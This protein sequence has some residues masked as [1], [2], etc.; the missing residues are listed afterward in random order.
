MATQPDYLASA[1]C[2]DGVKQYPIPNTSTVGSGRASLTAGFPDETSQPIDDGGIPPQRKDFNGI[3]YMLS[4]FAL[5][6]QSGGKFTWDSRV[7]Y[8]VPSIIYYNGELWWCVSASGPSVTGVGAKTPND[9]N[10]AY[11]KKVKDL[12]YTPL[13]AYPVGSY[14]ISS[15]ATNPANLAGFAGSTWV[16]VQNRMILAAG[17]S[18]TAGSTG[19]SATKTLTLANMPKHSHTC[20]TTGNHSH[21]INKAGKHYHGAMGENSGFGSLYG[22][23]DSGNTHVGNGSSDRDNSIWRTSTDGEHTH[24]MNETGNHKH[25]IGEA[26]SGTA[27]NIMPPYIVAYVWRRTA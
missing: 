20:G 2:T 14:Y 4:S 7:N 15:N 19:G 6:E 17:S 24:T 11:W 3:L 8:D 1:F 18:Y 12:F 5:F 9:A 23:Y 16:R 26:G 21:T 27:F 10:I 25:T 13:D 22:F